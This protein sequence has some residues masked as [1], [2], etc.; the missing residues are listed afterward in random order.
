[1]AFFEPHPPYNGPFNDEHPLDT[2]S[3]DPSA[4]NIFG[5][6]MPLRYRVRQEFYRSQHPTAAEYRRIKQKYLG[7]ISEIDRSI[8]AILAKVD[9]LGL[10]DRT[11]TVLT[12]DHGD[13]MSAHGLLGKQLMFEQS[14]TVPYLVRLPGETPRRCSQPIS[15]IDFVPT[16]LDLLGKPVH[17]QCSGKSRAG[18]IRGETTRADFIF[19]Q[20]APTKPDIA[21]EHSK[22]ASKDEVADLSSRINPCRCFARWLETLSPR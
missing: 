7:L 19:L 15:H 12:S 3:L 2:I 5:D 6:D 1:M 22:L 20:W 21:M 8:G 18:L 11:I 9:D 4:D 16:I 13:M 10:R 14:A 17:S